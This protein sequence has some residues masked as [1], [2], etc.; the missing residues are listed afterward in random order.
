M[1]RVVWCVVYVRGWSSPSQAV[2]NRFLYPVRS[3][4][5]P[6]IVVWASLHEFHLGGEE[7]IALA[8]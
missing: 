1:L 2:K 6:S 8:H 3:S 5:E 7:T 4:A